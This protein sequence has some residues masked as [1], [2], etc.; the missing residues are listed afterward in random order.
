M[1]YLAFDEL[2]FLS[3]PLLSD[4]HVCILSIEIHNFYI[5]GTVVTGNYVYFSNNNFNCFMLNLI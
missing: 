3:F 4:Y 1:K 5:D 2:Y